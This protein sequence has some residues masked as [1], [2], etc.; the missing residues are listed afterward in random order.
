MYNMHLIINTH[1]DREYRWS[2]AETQFRLAESVDDLINIMQRD[3]E[4]R[5]FH[6]DSQV[7]MLDDYLDIRPERREELKELVDIYINNYSELEII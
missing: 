4:F 1:W 3:E 7:S 6:T 2:F 5:H